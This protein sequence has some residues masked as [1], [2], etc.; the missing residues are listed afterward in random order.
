[1]IRTMEKGAVLILTFIIMAALVV[2]LAAFIS[3]TSSETKA[4]GFSAADAKA[5]WIAEGGIQQVIYK[6]KT[7]DSYRIDPDP[8]PLTGGLGAGNYSVQ[9][10]GPAGSTYTLVSTGTVSGLAR[11][12]TQSFITSTVPDAFKYS[13][14]SGHNIDFNNSRG[15]VNGADVSA[16]NNINGESHMNF[17][18]G[19]DL[20][21]D[22]T[23]TNPT[24]TLATYAALATPATTVSGNKIFTAGTYTGIWYVTGTVQIND[25]VIFNGTIVAEKAIDTQ[26]NAHITLNPTAPY[27]ALVTRL[28]KSITLNLNE[29]TINGLIYSG[30]NITINGHDK[31]IAINGS[32]IADNN[33]NISN[34]DGT[35][36]TYSSSL[37]SNPPPGFSA[38]GQ[39]VSI[40]A[41]KDWNE[42]T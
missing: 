3:M 1:M 5:L 34:G 38:V 13:F 26:N 7:D 39:T 31:T 32:L 28:N 40:S 24:V 12:I 2:L 18:G 8:N 35:T 33:V 29:S 14:H 41:Q 10:T 37:F 23:V 22:S 36:I 19:V 21:E 27:P 11:S 42:T 20:I 25:G 17:G 9:V 16:A 15:T 30:Q 6:L 4:A